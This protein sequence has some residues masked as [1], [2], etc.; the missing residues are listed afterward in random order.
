M[1]QIF[2]N[3]AHTVADKRTSLHL[4]A[5]TGFAM[6]E[7]D[8]PKVDIFPEKTH[9]HLYYTLLTLSDWSR[10]TAPSHHRQ[11]KSDQFSTHSLKWLSY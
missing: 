1:R 3:H 4:I 5:V 11:I 2:G 9:F 8:L 10:S 7:S 6:V